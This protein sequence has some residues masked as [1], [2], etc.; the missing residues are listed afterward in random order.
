MLV[1]SVKHLKSRQAINSKSYSHITFKKVKG[2]V[3]KS[4]SDMNGKAALSFIFIEGLTVLLHFFF[5]TCSWRL[6]LQGFREKQDSLIS[7]SCLIVDMM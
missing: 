1:P 4:D 3:G 2:K 6:S 5:L 7:G